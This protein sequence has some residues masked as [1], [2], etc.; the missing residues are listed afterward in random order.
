MTTFPLR[1]NVGA[2]SQYLKKVWGIDMATKTLRNRTCQGTGPQWMY[3]GCRPYTTTALLD[4]WVE[5]NFAD[6]PANGRRAR[7]QEVDKRAVDLLPTSRNDEGV[8]EAQQAA[9]P[10]QSGQIILQAC[11]T[12]G[13]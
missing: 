6:A 11:S 12:S 3:W 1:L 7:S 13:S 10:A 4:E 8:I 2:A 9:P 5:A